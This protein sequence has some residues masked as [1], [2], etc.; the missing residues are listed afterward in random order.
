MPDR[1]YWDSSA[2]L[3]F[4]ADQHDRRKK[5]RPVVSR[6]QNGEIEIVTSALT[7]SECLF[8]PEGNLLPRE[9]R[10]K[11]R[12]FFQHEFIVIVQ[13]DRPT[14]LRS[15]DL[16][17]DH[18]VAAKDALHLASALSVDDL[19]Q[20]DTF[21]GP[22]QKLDGK[23]GSSPPLRIGEPNLEPTAEELQYEA[24]EEDAEES[25]SSGP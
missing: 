1:R 25:P 9:H 14:A 6:A 13:I 10:S 5:C 20:F 19:E 21:D 2:F 16:V 8:M 3:G 11:V 12:Q 4:F 18:H 24:F 15:Q 23:L 7:I 17:W 22:L